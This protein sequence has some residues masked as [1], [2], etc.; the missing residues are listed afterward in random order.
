M[1][2]HTGP[3]ETLREFTFAET[4]ERVTSLHGET[5]HECQGLVP[6]DP[7]TLPVRTRSPNRVV[8]A[9]RT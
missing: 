2:E 7:D 5:A 9:R 3:V 1:S 6:I 8:T 4:L